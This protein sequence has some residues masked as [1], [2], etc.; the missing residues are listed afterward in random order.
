MAPSLV[1]TKAFAGILYNSWP[2]LSFC[3][4]HLTNRNNPV[5]QDALLLFDTNGN[6]R[7]IDGSTTAWTSN[8]TGEGVESAH[9][10]DNG[11][12]IL[13]TADGNISWQSFSHPSDTL[14]PGQALTV[15]QELTS[16]RSRDSHGS[17]FYTLKCY[18]KLHH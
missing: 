15:S 2:T 12:F 6:L 10:S 7:L 14:L 4:N 5:T 3:F 17:G 13:Y 8:T 18:K 16:S 1:F 11:N 9:M